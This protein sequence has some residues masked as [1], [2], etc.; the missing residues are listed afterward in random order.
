MEFQD[1]LGTLFGAPRTEEVLTALS[2]GAPLALRVVG[3]EGDI[4]AER[5]EAVHDPFA[6][7]PVS[8][9]GEE[10]GRVE[11]AIRVGGGGAEGANIAAQVLSSF[12]VSQLEAES[13]LEGFTQEIVERYEEINLLYD[14]NSELGALF[15]ESEIA[16]RAMDTIVQII[17]VKTA[18]ILLA[19]PEGGLFTCAATGGTAPTVDHSFVGSGERGLLGL[20]A[21]QRRSILANSTGELPDNI[22]EEEKVFPTS[23]ILATPLLHSPGADNEILIGVAI[24]CGKA[25]GTFTSGDEKLMGAISSQ[26][27]TSI[28]NARMV[29]E[30]KKSSLF[31]RDMELAEQIQLTMLPAE[32]PE[33]PGAEIAGRCD[34]AVNVGG[35]YFDYIPTDDGGVSILLGDVTGHSLGAALMMMAARATLRSIASE[36]GGPA[37]VV[38]RSNALL[39]DDLDRSDLMISLV[40]GHYIP[41]K[42]R[43]LYANAGHN[44]P[45]RIRAA[46]GE[47]ETLASSGIILG[48]LPDADYDVNV[49][50]LEPGDLVFFYTDG[51]TEARG[52]GRGQ[53]GEERLCAVLR[54]NR[55]LSAREIIEVVANSVQVWIG[56]G[57]PTD[58][59]TSVV[60]KV[61]E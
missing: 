8:L 51:V 52:E 56:K 45:F 44:P 34:T 23:G 26:A 32:S 27:A 14:L 13:Q 49:L 31:Q 50:D 2:G 9:G 3:P 41:E 21:G 46:R 42:K 59:A 29:A 19:D 33:L 16:R 47:V 22:A 18:A 25:N 5:G 11:V 58:D 39:Y 38:R 12:L 30:L 6:T 61:H 53:F 1:V 48:V 7:S 24:L 10:V 37:E 28:Y 36:T 20:M 57:K 15:D 17:D 40:V 43:L 55:H 4:L 35:D 54:E 60:L